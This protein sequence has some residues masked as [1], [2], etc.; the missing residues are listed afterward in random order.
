VVRLA[1]L[2]IGKLADIAPIL[3]EL[4]D[5]AQAGGDDRHVA[6]TAPRGLQAIHA[7]P[8]PARLRCAHVAHHVGPRI[9]RH[10][11]YQRVSGARCDGAK[12]PTL[13]A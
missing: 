3:L 8:A 4:M 5:S 9:D 7:G 1:N 2:G 6:A 13:E 10:G 12:T 11:R